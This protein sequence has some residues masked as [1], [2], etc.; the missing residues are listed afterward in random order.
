[1]IRSTIAMILGAVALLYV[2][3]VSPPPA[4]AEDEIPPLILDERPGMTIRQ[5]DRDERRRNVEEDEDGTERPASGRQTADPSRVFVAIVNSHV[6]TREELDARIAE[7]F[8]A[9]E[10]EL[11]EGQKEMFRNFQTVFGKDT[12]AARIE[13]LDDMKENIEVARR[14][15]EGVAVQEWV[16]HHVLADEARRQGIAVSL[17]EFRQRMDE[18]NRDNDLDA[19]RVGAVLEELRIS[20]A[21]YERAIYDALLIERLIEKYVEANWTEEDL[22]RTYNENPGLFYTPERFHIAHFTISLDGSEYSEQVKRME[23]IARRVRGELRSGRNPE[24]LFAEEE[25][26]RMERGIWGGTGYFTFQEGNLPR[27]VE[28]EARKLR[29]GQTSDV[30]VNNARVGERIRP[31]SFHVI[32][33]LDS[34]PPTGQTFESALPAIRR[35]LVEVARDDLIARLRAS[36][37]HRM[38]I[39]LGGIPPQIIPTREEILAASNRAQ[40]INLRF[41]E[42]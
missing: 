36:G 15:E 23:E 16:E 30:I 25:Y 40:P 22:R 18:L 27:P 10:E 4:M 37:T 20:K 26:D 13:I 14:A 6:L 28:V 24:E 7:R 33:V 39:N 35:S 31:R 19:A 17:Q 9:Y 8:K 34:V 21:D 29:V 2:G 32:K 42:N 11:K 41:R 38:I 1:M 3:T 5:R 12:E